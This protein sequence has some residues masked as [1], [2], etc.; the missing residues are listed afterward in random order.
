MRTGVCILQAGAGTG[1]AST[2]GVNGEKN[3]LRRLARWDHTP[4]VRFSE[5][6]VSLHPEECSRQLWYR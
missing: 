1:G 3:C 5:G 4:S 2:I 6:L